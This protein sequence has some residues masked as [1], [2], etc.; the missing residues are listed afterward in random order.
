MNTKKDTKECFEF[1]GTKVCK[2]CGCS[3]D[4]CECEMEQEGR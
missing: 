2:V 1:A 3:D 4:S